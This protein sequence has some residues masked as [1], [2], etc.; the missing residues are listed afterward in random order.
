MAKQYIPNA[1]LKIENSQIYAV[2]G[3]S[4]RQPELISCQSWLVVL[5]IFIHQHDIESAYQTFQQIK[6]T[7]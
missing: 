3:W 7:R 2:F 4:N 6:L 5:E 1:F